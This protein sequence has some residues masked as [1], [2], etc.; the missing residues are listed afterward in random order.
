MPA[1]GPL[2]P[3]KRSS[4]N[5]MPSHLRVQLTGANCRGS[6]L[7]SLSDDP[8]AAGAPPAAFGGDTIMRSITSR[9]VGSTR[10][11]ASGKNGDRM[12][13]QPSRSSLSPAAAEADGVD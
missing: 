6:D 5:W 3:H 8:T 9:V 2:S 12:I 4:L 11:K 13:I 7:V 10:S 1:H